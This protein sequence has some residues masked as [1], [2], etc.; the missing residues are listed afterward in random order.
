MKPGA[1]PAAIFWSAAEAAGAAGLAFVSAFVIARAVG[2]A[3]LGIGTAAVSVHVLLWVGV[4]ALFADA[5]VQRA[6]LTDDDAAEAFWAS[7]GVG[8]LAAGAMAAAGWPLAAAFG[9]PR[10]RT[11]ALILALPLP[12]VGAGGAVQGR[13]TRARHYRLLAFRVLLGQGF[14]TIVGCA[15]AFA[16]AGAWAVVA[17]QATGAAAGAAVLLIGARWLPAPRWPGAATRGLLAVGTPLAASTLVLHGR[18]RAFLLLLGG[19]AGPRI[20]GEVHMAF[21]LVDALRE[22][23]STA[24]WRWLLPRFS[25][26][27]HDAAGLRAAM[28]RA[29]RHAGWALFPLCAGLALAL[30]PA[31]RLLLGSEWA[32]AA[33]AA[34]PLV[35]LAAWQ[36]LA[37][38]VGA[39][40]VARG[41][42]GIALRANL[43]SLLLLTAAVLALRPGGAL[44]PGGA[45]A[46]VGIWVAAQLLVAPYALIASARVLGC[47]VAA[48]LRPGLP[49]AAVAMAAWSTAMAVSCRGGAAA[50][51]AVRELTMGAI[52]AAGAAV[53]H[54]RPAWAGRPNGIAPIDPRPR[55]A[56]PAPSRARLTSPGR[57]F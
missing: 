35:G 19:A 17:Q 56:I 16:R 20:L 1:A 47:G 10:L 11:M 29:G 27:Q 12:L 8:V 48:L 22:L 9:D 25:E 42:P 31:T 30:G 23:A 18:Y 37:F 7:V 57:R 46:A 36:F 55:P 34:L 2:P 4:N 41:A 44:G 32:G 39:A 50:Q 52:F 21:R 38:P 26:L 45:L 33:T 43:A 14:G 51:W 28:A 3:A 6:A 53:W 40:T 24:L 15:A 54:A 13:L 49:A 5:I